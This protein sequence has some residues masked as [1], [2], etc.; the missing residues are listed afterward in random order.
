MAG[1][2]T[3]VMPALQQL[4]ADSTTRELTRPT[5]LDKTGDLTAVARAVVDL[6]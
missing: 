1:L 4:T 6:D 3:R 2:L 5:G